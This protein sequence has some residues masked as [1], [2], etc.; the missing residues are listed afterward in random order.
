MSSEMS[1]SSKTIGQVKWFNNKAG[2][3]FITVKEEDGSSKDIFAH[4]TNLKADDSQYKYL[5]QGE[6]V[7][8]VLASLDDGKHEVQAKEIT[9]INLGQ[10][11][12]ETRKLN[13]SVDQ[14]NVRR[15]PPNPVRNNRRPFVKEQRRQQSV[16]Q[17]Q[18]TDE[19]GFTK[20]TKK[21]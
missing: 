19:D 8:F 20:V 2:Y 14:P 16:Q 1:S 5:V 9:G 11:M 17:Q 12:C 10:L 18:Q 13:S 3:G 7:E 4:Y 6:Y 15:G 21:N